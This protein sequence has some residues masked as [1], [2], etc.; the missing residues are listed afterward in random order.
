MEA[1]KRMLREKIELKAEVRRLRKMLSDMEDG[2]Y[3]LQGEIERLRD[4]VRLGYAE[5]FDDG[6]Y[7]AEDWRVP[8][9]PKKP[10]ERA[11]AMAEILREFFDASESKKSLTPEQ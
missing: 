4:L 10:S 3:H 6:R 1:A 7:A 8:S 2:Y 11:E 9:D 5:G